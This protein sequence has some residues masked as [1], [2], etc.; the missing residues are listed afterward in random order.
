MTQ[1]ASFFVPGTPIP[2]ARPRVVRGKGK[3][4]ITYTPKTTIRWERTV[5]AEFKRQCKGIFFE[6]SI[7]LKFYA[8]LV[9]P[10]AGSLTTIRGD[11]DNH[12]KSILDALN[13][14]AFDDDSQITDLHV[15]K[16]RARKGEQT[17]A[18]IVIEPASEVQ[19][20]LFGLEKTA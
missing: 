8:E 20:N 10:G 5:A 1:R 12:G 11:I 4:P 19:S 14:L 9:M 17:G 3:F 18:Y 13:S 16:R 6:K 7:A 2:K 15:L